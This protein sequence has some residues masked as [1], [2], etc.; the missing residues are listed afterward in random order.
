MFEVVEYLQVAVSF[1]VREIVVWVVP[2]ERVPVGEGLERMGGVVSK[3][4]YSYAPM[5]KV[6]PCGLRLPR[7]S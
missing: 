1:V 6:E 7:M 3:G 5:S 4:M 2:A